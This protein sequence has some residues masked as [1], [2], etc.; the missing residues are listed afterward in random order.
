MDGVFLHGTLRLTTSY[1][2]INQ[3]YYQIAMCIFYHCT[4]EHLVNLLIMLL[5]KS[6]IHK[7]QHRQQPQN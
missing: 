3:E 4:I 7:L 5:S 2:Q 1:C 6:H